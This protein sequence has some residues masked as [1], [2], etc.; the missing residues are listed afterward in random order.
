FCPRGGAE[1]ERG[2]SGAAGR[3]QRLRQSLFPAGRG[4]K[5]KH[6]ADRRP[7]KAPAATRHKSGSVPDGIARWRCAYRAYEV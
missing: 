7:G 2:A 5:A 6:D 3:R 4:G 1:P